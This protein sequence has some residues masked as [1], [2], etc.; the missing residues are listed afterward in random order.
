[1][2]T[3]LIV[4]DA[5]DN[6]I[7]FRT[8]TDEPEEY[9]FTEIQKLINLGKTIINLSDEVLEQKAKM[10]EVGN[11]KIYFFIRDN[12]NYFLITTGKGDFK[13]DRFIEK[14]HEVLSKLKKPFKEMSRLE[15]HEIWEE[16]VKNVFKELVNLKKL[17]DIV[18]HMDLPEEGEFNIDL[19][20][21]LNYDFYHGIPIKAVPNSEE[22]VVLRQVANY[23]LNEDFEL[24]LVGAKTSL[25]RKD[26]DLAKAILVISAINLNEYEKP[27]FKVRLSDLLLIVSTIKDFHLRNYL[28]KKIRS[29]ISIKGYSE[30]LKFGVEL[31]HNFKEKLQ[32]RE[33]V[34]L[35]IAALQFPT[36][37]EIEREINNILDYKD[38]F[39]VKYQLH[40]LNHEITEYGDLDIDKLIDIYSKLQRLRERIIETED[41]HNFV[42]CLE[43]IVN[44]LLV[45]GASSMIDE[46]TKMA[47]IK[48]FL[49][50][51]KDKYMDKMLMLDKVRVSRKYEVISKVF[52]LV[53][54][55]ILNWG[56]GDFL[57]FYY[58]KGIETLKRL[59]RAAKEALFSPPLFYN[60]ICLLLA[61]LM[62]IRQV[63]PELEERVLIGKK[64]LVRLVEIGEDVL[65]L[66]NLQPEFVFIFYI[67]IILMLRSMIKDFGKIRELEESLV[68]V[69]DSVSDNHSI[70]AVLKNILENYLNTRLT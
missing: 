11:N 20:T 63:L 32:E 43:V 6:L 62:V 53:I 5:N 59:F 8:F 25:K 60:S 22:E 17:K 34:A 57:Y 7:Y 65:E 54:Q 28:E 9:R 70:K 61:A 21:I 4:M 42:R 69:I 49:I 48:D 35:F 36:D 12:L 27:I 37:L 47:I 16:I 38:K 14:A 64:F 10:L 13:F 58:E 41:H 3:D 24:A 33:D 52:G 19:D 29:Y 51:F 26:S 66:L 56:K 23:A 30:A 15:K 50:D 68:G 31:F 18:T 44:L 46:E 40:L 2:I 55:Y 1:M 67:S 39:E 45:A